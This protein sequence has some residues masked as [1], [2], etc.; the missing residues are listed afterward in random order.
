[1][2]KGGITL[3]GFVGTVVLTSV[4]AGCQALG[5]TRINLPFMLGTMVTSDRDRAK[6]IGFGMHLVNGWLFAGVYAAAFRSW[7][8]AT[9][10]LGALVG[11]V[12]ALFVLLVGMPML[13][14]LHPRMASEQHGP[15]PT[16]QLEPPGV[17][18]LNYGRR[19]PISVIL[20]HL[21][22]GAIL[23]AFYRPR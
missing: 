13:P 18:A 8:R 11:L 2:N 3:W 21:L 17:L 9:W 1:M 16:R 22:Y 5:L 23:G 20:A 12:H 7:R 15:T 19:T 14:S 10:W 4:L 6:L